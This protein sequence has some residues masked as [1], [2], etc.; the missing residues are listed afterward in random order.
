MKVRKPNWYELI[1]LKIFGKD[2]IANP[3]TGDVAD[4]DGEI[5]EYTAA[6]EAYHQKDMKEDGKIGYLVTWICQYILGIIKGKD[7]KNAYLTITY[8]KEAKDDARKKTG[9]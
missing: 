5:S 4:R 7:S 2:T 3:L 1:L 6:E 9:G 8:E